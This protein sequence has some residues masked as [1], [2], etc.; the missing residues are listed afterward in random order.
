MQAWFSLLLAESFLAGCVLL[1]DTKNGA[2][3]PA[4]VAVRRNWR[5]DQGADV[6]GVPSPW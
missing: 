5:R 3:R 1:Q 2:A 4:T 6:E